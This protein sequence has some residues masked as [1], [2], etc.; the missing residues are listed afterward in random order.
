MGD[1]E[2]EG[3]LHLIP[4]E[5]AE[6]KLQAE[7]NADKEKRA[8]ARASDGSVLAREDAMEQDESAADTESLPVFGS[9]ANRE[10]T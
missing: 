10:M 8:A 9:H 3:H 5:S 6:S 4:D 7:L 1:R 2:S